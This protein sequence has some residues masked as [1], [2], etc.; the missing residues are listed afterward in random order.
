[1]SL[2]EKVIC[3][4]FVGIMMFNNTIFSQAKATPQ[5]QNKVNYSVAE[6]QKIYDEG[7]NYFR[8]H[9]YKKAIDKQDIVIKANPK[10]YK[11]F[12]V[13]GIAQCFNGSFKEGM[14]NIDKSLS[15]NS[16]YDYSR[17]NKALAY[18][19]YHYYN[20]AIIWYNKA[21]LIKKDVWSY[22]GIASIYGR[23][24]DVENTVKYL[25]LAKKIMP[26]VMKYAKDEKDFDKVRN[27]K[28]FKD[29]YSLQ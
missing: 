11:A 6:I 4:A 24:G 15:I 5:P 26:G 7:Y 9:E 23:W 29:L 10:H 13:K 22:Y 28:A 27:S 2:R 12:N 20:D 19:L 16:N 14:K 21:L 8:A 1:M 18:E 17:F 3:I 25:K